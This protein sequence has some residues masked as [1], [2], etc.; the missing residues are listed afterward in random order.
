VAFPRYFAINKNLSTT[1]FGSNTIDSYIGVDSPIKY[2]RIENLPIYGMPEINNESE[3]D[4]T[5]GTSSEGYSGEA[6]ILPGVM[7]PSE[8]ECFVLE[9]FNKRIL[10]F[11]NEVVEQTI[12]AN[13]AYIIRFSIESADKIA[14]IER[15]V[16]SSSIAIFDNIGTENRVIIESTDYAEVTRLTSIYKELRD[17]FINKFFKRKTTTFELNVSYS[18]GDTDKINMVDKF[19]QKFLT[20]NRIIIMDLLLKDT[21]TLDYNGL[22]RDGDDFIYSNTLFNAVTNKNIDLLEGNYYIDVD[23]LDTPFSLFKG[24]SDDTL[25]VSTGYLQSNANTDA[26][27]YIKWD[28]TTIAQTIK[29]NVDVDLNTAVVDYNKLVSLISFYFNNK[30]ITSNFLKGIVTSITARAMTDIEKYMMYPIIMY[31]IR[32]TIESKTKSLYNYL[33]AE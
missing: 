13:P 7:I 25:Y 10:F 3:F 18:V 22:Y 29:D 20:D 15:Q 5:Y 31:I 26:I 6:T 16:V 9:Y 33:A 4:E 28:M 8:G 14:L 17:Y 1:G 11:V 21:L 27:P 2:D 12:K 30:E 24:Y 19:M 32:Y 23:K